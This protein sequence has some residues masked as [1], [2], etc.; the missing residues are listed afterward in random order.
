MSAIVHEKK[1]CDCCI[2]DCVRMLWYSFSP[3]SAPRAR[4]TS[5]SLV[6]RKMRVAVR[7]AVQEVHGLLR[8]NADRCSVLI[9]KRKQDN[10]TIPPYSTSD[11]KQQY[12]TKNGK[13]ITHSRGRHWI[14]WQ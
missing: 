9:Q 13:R 10:I 11:Q 3:F 4:T 12:L 2:L 1:C 8:K 6:M 14:T 7:A 5:G